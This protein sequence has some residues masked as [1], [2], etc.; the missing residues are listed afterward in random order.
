MSVRPL[1]RKD[2]QEAA[3]AAS[4]FTLR[5]VVA[6]DASTMAPQQAAPQPQVAAA[7]ANL[8][9]SLSRATAA[10]T[11]PAPPVAARPG[12]PATPAAPIFKNAAKG[13][14]SQEIMRLTAYISDLSKRLQSTGTKLQQTEVNLARTSQALVAERHTSQQRFANM[15]AELVAAQETES[16]LRHE[17][18]TQQLVA[19]KEQKTKDFLGTVRSAIATNEVSEHQRSEATALE[20]RVDSMNDQKLQLEAHINALTLEKADAEKSLETAYAKVEA[21]KNRAAQIRDR[22]TVEETRLATLVSTAPGEEGEAPTLAPEELDAAP[23]VDTTCCYEPYEEPPEAL[24]PPKAPTTEKEALVSGEAPS[25]VVDWKSEAL[26]HAARNMPGAFLASHFDRDAPIDLCCAHIAAE[27]T[28]AF[29]PPLNGFDPVSGAPKA[30]MDGLIFAIVADMKDLL[31]ES[32]MQ[33]LKMEEA[34]A[35]A[36]APRPLF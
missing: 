33:T 28:H 36:L 6:P 19:A 14:D 4:R 34:L 22:V 17:L 3:A 18:K 25:R 8:R 31:Q 32:H 11:P 24:E 30:N 21:E 9:F 13:T 7:A 20:K 15:Q 5:G 35:P 29:T 16:K 12:I 2:V 10:A 27:D 1:D 26:V 23:D